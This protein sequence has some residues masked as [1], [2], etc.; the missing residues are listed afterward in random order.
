MRVVIDVP[1]RVYKAI[2]NSTKPLLY[3]EHL[4]QE[5][6]ALPKGH[7]RLIDADA[8]ITTLEATSKRQKYKELL[9]DNHF[10]TVDDVFK[11][12]IESLQNEGLSEGDSPTIIEAESEDKYE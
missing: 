10:L 3:V 7:G 12:V 5:G 9:I 2:K 6:T 1:D 4:I 11:A 8:F